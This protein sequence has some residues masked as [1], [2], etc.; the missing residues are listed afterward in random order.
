MAV[1]DSNGGDPVTETGVV[2]GDPSAAG[3]VLTNDTDVDTGDTRTV[4]AV[5][6]SAPNVGAPLVGIYGTLT[7]WPTAAGPM[8]STTPIPTPTR[9]RR[10][11]PPATPLPT[12]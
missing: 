12:P 8:R 3:N 2:A 6:G 10:A 1:A 9:W 5:N 4:T 7:L 11:R